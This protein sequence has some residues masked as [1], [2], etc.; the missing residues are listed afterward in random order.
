MGGNHFN[1]QVLC[2]YMSVCVCMHKC[3]HGNAFHRVHRIPIFSSETHPLKKCVMIN[4]FL[5]L[6]TGSLLSYRPS[7][8]GYVI[9]L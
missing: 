9:N 3:V 4:V 7:Y 8:C 2:V 5:N 1:G 6:K